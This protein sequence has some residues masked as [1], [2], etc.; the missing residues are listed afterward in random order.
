M[1][2]NREF[3]FLVLFADAFPYKL[4]A[5][6]YNDEDPMHDSIRFQTMAKRQ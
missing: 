1:I 4:Y 6:R 5:G 3:L 2:R